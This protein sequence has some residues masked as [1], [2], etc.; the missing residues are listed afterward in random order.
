MTERPD[1]G[2]LRVRLGRLA[3]DQV[4]VVLAIVF[5]V[6]AAFYIWTA[7][8]SIPLALNGWSDDPYNRL[9]TAFLHFH[10]SALAAPPGLLHLPEPYDPNQNAPFQNSLNIHDYILYGG[11]LYVSWGPAPVLT[12]L[13]PMHLLGLG[14]SVSFVVTVFSVVGLGFALAALRVLLRWARNPSPWICALAAFAVAISSMVPTILRRPEVYESAV[15]GGFCFAMAGIWLAM[16]ALVDR[17]TSLPRL[18]L[19]SLSFGLA[20]GSRPTLGVL[21][22]L[23]LP[24]YLSLR[25]TPTR[26][27]SLLA[28]AGPIAVCFLLLMAYNQARFGSPTEF[29]LKYVLASWNSR[30]EVYGDPNYLLP[31][32]WNYMLSPPRPM[33]L[34]P[35]VEL[36]PPPETYPFHSNYT[37]AQLIGGFLPMT[38][39]GIFLIGLPWLWRRRP[40]LLE[41]LSPVFLICALSGVLTVLFISYELPGSAERY[42][43]DFTTLFMLGSLGVWLALG[44][45][46]HGRARRLVHVGG[47]V[48]LAWGCLMGFAVSLK[49]EENLLATNYPGLWSKLERAGEPISRV[50]TGLVGHPAVTVISS[51]DVIAVDPVG[52]LGLG[53]GP[54]TF[55]FGGAEPAS[56]T[57]V[58]PGSR[59]I[60]LVGTAYSAIVNASGGATRS[61]AGLTHIVVSGP[62]NRSYLYKIPS[63]GG[64]PIRLPLQLDGGV[65][66][67][68]LTPEPTIRRASKTGRP[69]VQALEI[70]HLAL[71]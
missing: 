64:G 62:G 42:T 67:I 1:A 29:G 2:G 10:V 4:N 60:E 38:P 43:V 21:G 20:T 23:L 19:M 40:A 18:A 7:A 15:A 24:V 57:I 59:K 12:L 37:G 55:A 56:I 16:S 46:L 41:P 53:T 71:G 52:Y 6:A 45:S 36:G 48:L 27:A 8:T 32:T 28:L 30:T 68:Q 51:P 26:R 17:R 63:P 9:A 34:F 13:V 47:G 31:A 49:G 54:T 44:N 14:P 39:I 65:N 66:H 35:F 22:L 11:Q 33:A 58:S 70:L 61:L 5:L 50:L 3:N 25:G 69:P